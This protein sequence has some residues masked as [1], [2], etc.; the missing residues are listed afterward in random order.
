MKDNS[1]WTYIGLLFVPSKM[2]IKLLEFLS[3]LRC[4]EHNKWSHDKTKC[5]QNCNYHEKNFTEIH[6][7]V[8]HRSNARYRIAK[9]WIEFIINKGIRNGYLSFNILGLNIS[10]MNLNLFGDKKGR[11]YTI[12]NRFFRSILKGSI[13]YFY[14]KYEKVIISKIYHDKGG[15]QYHQYFPWHA[16]YKL[17]QNINKLEISP[18]NIEFIDSDHRK[19]KLDESHLIQLIDLI[20]GATVINFHV[21]TQNIQQRKIGLIFKPALEI[22]IDRKQKSSGWYGKYYS[23]SKFTRKCAVS[24]FPKV[25]CDVNSKNFHTNL[26]GNLTTLKPN[27]NYYYFNRKILL[28]KDIFSKLDKWL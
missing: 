25:Q 15:Q 6:Y 3:N 24:F 14:N 4:V 23:R 1:I 22:I 17:G 16:I 5:P 20:L 9:K 28:Q 19:S 8:L 26:N 10:K 7:Q 18:D 11:H 13:S 21:Q 2:K 27:E 12:Y